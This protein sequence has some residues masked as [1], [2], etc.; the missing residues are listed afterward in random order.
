M[1]PRQGPRP[2]GE[3]LGAVVESWVGPE[4]A[5]LIALARR[6]PEVVGDD[7][8]LHSRPERLQGAVLVVAVDRPPWAAAI[9][10]LSP[11]ICAGAGAVC[12]RP[13]RRVEVVVRPF[14]RDAV[15]DPDGGRAGPVG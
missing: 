4:G 8:A 10:R 1:S 2:L 3:L 12:P 13:P 11:Q 6:W 9:R 7:L 15:R 5:A 14:A